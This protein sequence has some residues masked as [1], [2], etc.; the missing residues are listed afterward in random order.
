MFP[1]Q[2]LEASALVAKQWNRDL[3]VAA[4]Q[5]QGKENKF[6]EFWLFSWHH[7]DQTYRHIALSYCF[8]STDD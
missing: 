5:K 4:S 3:A 1:T 6:H 8:L 2:H 7:T